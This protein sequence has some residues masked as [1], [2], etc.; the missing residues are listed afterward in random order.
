[1][2]AS[3]FEWT[4]R[5]AYALHIIYTNFA[6]M[7]PPSRK[8]VGLKLANLLALGALGWSYLSLSPS[9]VRLLAVDCCASDIWMNCFRHSRWIR[10]LLFFFV[11]WGETRLHWIESITRPK[12]PRGAQ[13]HTMRA[14]EVVIFGNKLSGRCNSFATAVLPGSPYASQNGNT[15]RATHITL[16][17]RLVSRVGFRLNVC[18]SIILLII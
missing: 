5:D 7:Q 15:A 2:W 10:W 18:N 12:R 17:I 4:A 9:R 11:P 1:M 8:S 16:L 3:S 6:Q 13:C 14:A